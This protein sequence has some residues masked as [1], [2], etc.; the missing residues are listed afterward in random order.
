MVV[1]HKGG[2]RGIVEGQGEGG[3]L[4]L[5]RAAGIVGWW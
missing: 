4:W 1:V 5:G 2:E 3:G